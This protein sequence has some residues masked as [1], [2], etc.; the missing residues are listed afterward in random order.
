[1]NTV[2]FYFSLLVNVIL[3]FAT[4]FLWVAIPDELTLNIG[5]TAFCL[6]LSFILMFVKRE[7]LAPIYRTRFFKHFSYMLFSSTCLFLIL[8]MVNFL[9]Y[10][11]P[12]QRDF[13]QARLSSLTD[14]SIN[15]VKKLDQNLSFKIFLKKMKA[16]SVVKFLERYRV[17]NSSIKIEVIDPE[18]NPAAIKKF[19][20]AQEGTLVVNYGKRW[21]SIVKL[22]ELE[23]TNAIIKLT[24][25]KDPVV[26][27]SKGH[28]EV[29]I[30]DETQQG[31]SLL[32]QV[33]KTSYYKVKNVNLAQISE[34]PKE[35]DCLVILGPKT[36]FFEHEVEMIRN[37]VDRGGKLL[38]GLMPDLNTKVEQA[39]H[40]N[41]ISML[42]SYGVKVV[43]TLVVDQ[44]ANV[45][46]SNGT[47]PLVSDYN[48]NHVVTRFFSGPTFFP[49][50]LSFAPVAE[51]AKKFHTTALVKTSK[52]PSSYG[53]TNFEDVGKGDWKF[54]PQHDL[55]GPLTLAMT[56]E[57][58]EESDKG[59]KRKLAVLGNSTF[60]SNVYYGQGRNFHFFLNILS[61]LTEENQLISLDRPFSSVKKI[62][63]SAPQK[64]VVMYFSILFAPLGLI[65]IAILF[66]IRRQKL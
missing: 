47:V 17:H 16:Q 18:L 1:M 15:V 45:S 56:S 54:D 23:I 11:F 50:S 24:R 61:W 14:Q 6:L 59:I 30:E 2:F 60:I 12:A 5:L 37:F 22:S 49:F 42:E 9:G 35:V 10:K 63:M 34:I 64:G 28:G 57:E 51:A 46:G 25:L 33:L 27:F 36:K 7:E 40:E 39:K 8:G 38:F 20:I 58:L 3:Y 48:K 66:Y 31:A 29:D 26:F 44:K 21:E 53:K 41:I 52:F 32:H 65:L 13:T 19:G 43:N 62:V 55:K 4:I